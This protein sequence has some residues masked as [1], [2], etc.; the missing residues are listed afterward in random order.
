[1]RTS[2]RIRGPEEGGRG[3]RRKNEQDTGLNPTQG[4]AVCVCVGGGG[5]GDAREI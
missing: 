5:G 2:S 1:M 3:G 4:V